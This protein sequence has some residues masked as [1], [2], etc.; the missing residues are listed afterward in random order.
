LAVNG[1]LENGDRLKIEKWLLDE[2]EEYLG[3]M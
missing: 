2:L 1:R 3:Q